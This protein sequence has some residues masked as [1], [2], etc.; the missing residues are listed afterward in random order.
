MK[1]LLNQSPALDDNKTA[2]IGSDPRFKHL[3]SSTSRY[4]KLHAS[5]NKLHHRV[6]P[7]ESAMHVP[8]V[9]FGGI[10]IAKHVLPQ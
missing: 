3:Q 8:G 6:D 4:T 9:A 2:T 10:R 1:D 5:N 7:L